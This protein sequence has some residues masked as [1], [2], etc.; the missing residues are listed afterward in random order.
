MAVLLEHVW[1]PQGVPIVLIDLR[2]SLFR[3]LYAY[4]KQFPADQTGLKAPQDK[5]NK[6][7]QCQ[8]AMLFNNPLPWLKYQPKQW[9]VGIVDDQRYSNSNVYWRTEIYA[10]YKANRNTDRAPSY[11]SLL[12]YAWQYLEADG[13]HIPIFRQAG[14]EADDWAGSAYRWA[15]ECNASNKPRQIMLYTSD[16]DW[17]QLVDRRYG[18]YWANAL[19]Y[20]PR[21]RSENEILAYCE[22]KGMGMLGHPSEIAQH[23][24]EFGDVSDNVSAGAPIEVVDLINPP[25]RPDASEFC[26]W[27]ATTDANTNVKHYRGAAQWLARNGFKQV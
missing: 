13:C 22:R 9:Q 16:S 19:V 10:E 11:N 1:R 7:M 8:W 23:K 20:K 24:A 14:F 6:W 15:R 18:I 21:L 4:Q 3:L 17:Q 5:R 25:Q 12:R 26:N 2:V 27:L